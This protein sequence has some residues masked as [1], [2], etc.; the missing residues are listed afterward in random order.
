MQ[1]TDLNWPAIAALAKDT[2]V[3]FP[4]AALEQ[5]GRHLP[6]FTDSL[7]LGEI[8]RRAAETV[9]NSVLFGNYYEGAYVG[10]GNDHATFTG[11]TFRDQSSGIEVRS[12]FAV[13]SGRSAAF[14]PREGAA[15][16][17]KANAR[18]VNLLII[19][20]TPRRHPGC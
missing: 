5:H 13:V 15:K 9:S 19:A 7:L 16:L 8:I 6:V 20:C 11:D 3:V 17:E 10:P 18:A 2:P 14:A 1:L 4:V 12:T